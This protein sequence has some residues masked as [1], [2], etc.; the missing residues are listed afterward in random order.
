MAMMH[1]NRRSAQR[2]A[3]AG[4]KLDGKEVCK[5]LI[6]RFSLNHRIT[7][8]PR[9][10]ISNKWMDSDEPV[11]PPFKLK[12]PNGVRSGTLQSKNN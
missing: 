8:E 1:K 6:D 2:L 9:H 11:Q 3:F 12:N 10:E 5:T 4:E 7:F